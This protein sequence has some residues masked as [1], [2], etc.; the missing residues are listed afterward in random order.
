MMKRRREARRQR[1][2]RI[3]AIVTDV[4][5]LWLLQWWRLDGDDGDDLTWQEECLV[6]CAS[7][8]YTKCPLS[9]GRAPITMCLA[10]SQKRF[11]LHCCINLHTVVHYKYVL[12]KTQ[13]I[14][15]T[16]HFSRDM[17]GGS[18][19][20]ISLSWSCI[21]PSQPRFQWESHSDHPSN[22][23]LKYF[24]SMELK[25]HE[26]LSKLEAWRCHF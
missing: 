12:Y 24:I 20:Y 7:D 1:R 9:K 14:N 4:V 5:W 16:M 8:Y 22:G 13:S 3:S 21:A 10:H 23:L 2:R 11:T 18:H 19:C 17:S 26:T 15:V 6:S 25:I